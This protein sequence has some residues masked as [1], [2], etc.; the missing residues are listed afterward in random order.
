MSAITITV[1]YMNRPI[2]IISKISITTSKQMKRTNYYLW[3]DLRFLVRLVVV[4]E[5]GKG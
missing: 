4:V 1:H 2:T 3:R 5:G